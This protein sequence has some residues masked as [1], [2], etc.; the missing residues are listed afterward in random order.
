MDSW[1]KNLWKKNK[2]LFA[3]ALPLIVLVVFKDLIM[4]YLIGSA[5]KMSNEAKDKDQELKEKQDK[6]NAEADKT[7][8]DADRLQNEIEDTRKEAGDEDW[9]KNWKKRE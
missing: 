1:I 4:E 5:R 6:L 3:I 8:A 7:K 2:I 9:H